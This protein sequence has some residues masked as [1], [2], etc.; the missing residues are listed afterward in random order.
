MQLHFNE[1]NLSKNMIK[2]RL[3]GN[4]VETALNCVLVK[5]TNERDS[6]QK[7]IKSAQ[8][9]ENRIIRQWRYLKIGSKPAS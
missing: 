1:E 7:V 6:A 3:T 8:K 9:V 5:K 2:R 4:F